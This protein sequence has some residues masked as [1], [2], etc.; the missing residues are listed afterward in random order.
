MDT[1]SLAELQERDAWESEQANS[2]E[3]ASSICPHER[4]TGDKR[5]P[6]LCDKDQKY[7]TRRFCDECNARRDHA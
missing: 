6:V 5:W 7:A 3:Y 4:G 2:Y 1:P